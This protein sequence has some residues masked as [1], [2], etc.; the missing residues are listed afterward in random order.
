MMLASMLWSCDKDEDEL[1]GEGV[2]T[3]V[4]EA[5]ESEGAVYSFNEEESITIDWG[6][7]TKGEFQTIERYNSYYKEYEYVYYW[8][9]SYPNSNKHTITIK[10]N[11][12]KFKVYSESNLTALDVS[13]CVTLKILECP[14]DELTSLNIGKNTALTELNCFGA[15]LTTLDVSR[16]TELTELDCTSNNLSSLDVSKCMKL[17]R[18]YCNDSNLSSLSISR[19]PEWVFIDCD[20]NNFSADALN[21]IFNDLPKSNNNPVIQIYRN[22][23]SETCDTSIAEDKGWR[24]AF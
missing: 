23:G 2:I 18:L 6:D 13:R 15:K 19:S 20:N 9:H 17:K 12:K 24:V 11:I 22:P 14:C 5:D 3:M 7:G 21:K 1:D 10:G 16:C 8:K 4:V